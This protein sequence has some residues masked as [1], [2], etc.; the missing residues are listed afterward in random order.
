MNAIGRRGE[1]RTNRLWK[2]ALPWGARTR[3]GLMTPFAEPGIRDGDRS[4]QLGVT[5]APYF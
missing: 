3:G 1:W 4:L 5:F 2:H